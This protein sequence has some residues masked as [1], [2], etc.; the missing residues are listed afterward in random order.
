V[1]SR[2][3]LLEN[4]QEILF[5]FASSGR[6]NRFQAGF[7]WGSQHFCLAGENKKAAQKGGFP[8]AFK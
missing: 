3:Q 6:R 1:G 2:K 4:F 7:F 8:A 5:I